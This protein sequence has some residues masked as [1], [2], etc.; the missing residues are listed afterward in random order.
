[1]IYGNVNS[2]ELYKGIY[3][4][5]DKAIDFIIKN[6]LGSL[7]DGRNEIDGDELF[8]NVV[9]PDLIPADEGIY[10]YHRK[11]LDLHI[12]I[13]GSEKVLFTALNTFDITHEYED[14]G[15]YALGDGK[16]L[17]EC[18]VDSSHFCICMLEEPHKPCCQIG[19]TSGR[20][21]KAI[22]KIKVS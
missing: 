2:L 13:E 18:N 12:D 4:N 15:D 22:F 10:E 7:T 3:P 9:T 20:I 14:E 19:E 6:D 5:L 21:R 1:M 8:I 16:A 11:Y 17:A